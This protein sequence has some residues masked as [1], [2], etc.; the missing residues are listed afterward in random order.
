VLEDEMIGNLK[1][2]WWYLI[3]KYDTVNNNNSNAIENKKLNK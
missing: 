1:D 3:N 2:W